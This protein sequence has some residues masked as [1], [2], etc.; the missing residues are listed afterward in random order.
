[1]CL[2]IPGKVVKVE[3]GFATIDYSGEQRKASTELVDV[4]AGDYVIVQAQF[5]IQKIPEKE[6]IEAI[7]VWQDKK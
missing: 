7:K 4:D 5:I 3:K 2:A 6:A 1:M